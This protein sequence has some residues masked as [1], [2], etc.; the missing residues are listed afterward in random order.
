MEVSEEQQHL[1]LIDAST[2]LVLLKQMIPKL[3]ARG[4]RI[5]IFSQFKIVLN[6]LESFF[7]G[8]GVRYTRIVSCGTFLFLSSG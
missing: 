4:H 1:N 3:R 8:E 5:L 7:Q 2:K 6:I